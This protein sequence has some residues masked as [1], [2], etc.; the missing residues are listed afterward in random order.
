M[1]KYKFNKIMTI[2]FALVLL[3]GNFQALNAE[4]IVNDDQFGLGKVK[5]EWGRKLKEDVNL[6]YI[7][8]ENKHG[9]QKTHVIEFKPENSSI[10]AK[11]VYGEYMA[12][13]NTLSSLVNRENNN[14]SEVVFAIN[15]DGYDTSNMVPSGMMIND[16]YLLTSSPSSRKSIGF[17]QNGE[18]IRGDSNIEISVKTNNETYKVNSFNKERKN[19]QQGLYLLSDIFSTSTRSTY[20]GVEVVLSKNDEPEKGLKINDSFDVQVESVNIVENNPSMNNTKI[21]HNKMVLSAHKNSKH[22]E[23]LKDL[24]ENQ[25]LE[26]ETVNKSEVPWDKAQTAIG[27]FT[28][29]KEDGQIQSIV[30]TDKDYHPRTAIGITKD[31]RLLLMQNDGRQ[32]GHAQGVT[33]KEI[34]EH[35]SSLGAETVYNFDGGGSSTVTAKLPGYEDATVLNRPSDGHERSNANALLFIADKVEQSEL[36][37]LHIYP[38]Q[39]F[40]S[41]VTLLEKGEIGFE[42]FGTDKNYNKVAINKEDIEWEIDGQIG[43][44]ENQV[45][46]ANDKKGNGTVKVRHKKHDAIG[47]LDVDVVD[48]LTSLKSKSTIISVGP[49]NKTELEF[50]GEF[51]G[52]TVLLSNRSLSFKLSD[53]K[54]GNV[55]EDG[56]FH[57]NDTSGTGTLTVSYKDY[58]IDIPVEVG[59]LPVVLNGFERELEEDNWHWRFFNSGT[60]GGD[61]K[62][63][64]NY[65]ERYIKRGDGS[66]RID[67][68]NATNPVTGT[69]TIEAG[70][71][72]GTGQLEGKPKAIGMWVY[73]DGSGAWIRIQLK[74]ASY[75]GDVKVDWTGWKYIETPIPETATFPYDLVWGIRVLTL[76]SSPNNHKKGTLYF[77]EL[78]AVYDFKNDDLN[79][80][81]LYDEKS[82]YPLEGSTNV[83]NNSEIGLHVIDS[84]EDE[85]S[86]TGINLS[87]TKLW[88]NGEIQE[89]VQQEVQ[90]DGSVK[91]SYVPSA[92]KLLRSGNNHVKFR[93]EDN[94][95]NKFFKEWSFNV[96][97]YA[98]EL[99]ESIPEVDFL[100]P[101]QIVEYKINSKNFK[102][103][104]KM[105]ALLSYNKDAMKLIDIKADEKLDLQ[106]NETDNKIEL[107]LLGMNKYQTKNEMLSLRFKILDKEGENSNLVFDNLTVYE[108]DK[109]PAR[110]FLKGMSKEVKIPYS[111]S[112]DGVTHNYPSRFS[113][114]DINGKP[115]QNMKLQVLDEN[116]TELIIDKNSDEQGNII[117]D[118]ITKNKV[119][120]KF[121]IYAIDSQGLK[122]NQVDFV[123]KESLGT[124]KIEKVVVSTKQD[125]SKELGI[126][127]QT[128]LNV[129]QSNI[130][131]SETESFEDY[132][133]Y[134]SKSKTVPYNLKGEMRLAKAW[135]SDLTSLKPDTEYFYRIGESLENSD[136]FTLKTANS[137]KDTI[138]KFYGDFQGAFNNY[139]KIEKISDEI[140]DADLIMHAGDYSDNHN[141]YDE[142]GLIDSVLHK[143]TSSKIWAHTIGNHDV[144]ENG[145]DNVINAY[146]N[147]PTNGTDKNG[148]NYYF[149]HG[150]ARIYVMDSEAHFTYDPG[151]KNQIKH[152]EKVFKESDQTYKIVMVH[153]PPYGMSYNEPWMQIL[154]KEFDRLGI[155]LVLS[156]HD[157]IY[158]RTT[159]LDNQKVELNQGPT[160]VIMG[161]S[162][163]SK[164]YGADRTRPWTNVVY[165]KH[166]P[167]FGYIIMDENGLRFETYAYVNDEAVKIDEFL[168]V[169]N[170]KEE[171]LNQVKELK[172]V[173]DYKVTSSSLKEIEQAILE[174]EE[175]ILN[176]KYQESIKLV[177]EVKEQ[178]VFLSEE[179]WNLN[180]T[181][182]NVKETLDQ[183]SI[184]KIETVLNT[185][186][187]KEISSAFELIFKETNTEVSLEQMKKILNKSFFSLGVDYYSEK[188]LLKAENLI[189]ENKF[190]ELVQHIF[191]MKEEYDES[192]LDQIKES[193]LT[194]YE[195]DQ[196]VMTMLKENELDLESL[197]I[198]LSQEIK[199]YEDAILLYQTYLEDRYQEDRIIKT[200]LNELEQL[201]FEEVNQETLDV[202]E[203]SI[204]NVNEEYN[205][206]TMDEFFKSWSNLKLLNKSA[207]E[208][209][210][211]FIDKYIQDGNLKNKTEES[212]KNLVLV[213]DESKEALKAPRS[214]QKDIDMQVEKLRNAYTSLKEIR[215]IEVSKANIVQGEKF[216]LIMKGFD[217]NSE[218]EIM[219]HS[220]PILLGKVT[221]DS[222]GYAKVNLTIPKDTKEG[223]HKIIIDGETIE[224]EVNSS[225]ISVEPQPPVPKEPDNSN[226]KDVETDSVV[227]N[228][229]EVITDNGNKQDKHDNTNETINIEDLPKTGEFF[230]NNGVTF[231]N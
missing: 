171:A 206:E 7:S 2:L 113:I 78:R 41:S 207:L 30:N 81:H 13:G 49:G 172:N 4:E 195:K 73:G 170:Y 44:I 210:I 216:D 159:M 31:N 187:N 208:S 110:L 103:F 21:G 148:R 96:E 61:G 58:A 213:L 32:A 79:A 8:S 151:F 69:V 162:T 26:I 27:I 179:F 14:K 153:R 217:K 219:L 71:K 116:G 82:I 111:L 3:L 226:G 112:Y 161:T 84:K 57:A 225:S 43:T 228:D 231:L 173:I 16:G 119:G 28:V 17:L 65:D 230:G 52:N 157:H 64:I 128:S 126:S 142:W 76:P 5:M 165:D 72:V 192:Y 109:K 176:E 141:D 131:V 1:K 193:T 186:D 160:Y 101:G 132:K 203:Q 215:S 22:Y 33:F 211:S 121:K 227:E 12:G 177:R 67:Y 97:G 29:L 19:D 204:K 194:S 106:Y 92:L 134:P 42:V 221:T 167:S 20:E 196:L 63:S 149:D 180:F 224:I 91:I 115:A 181:F 188:D 51:E 9:L 25:S 85:K 212:K 66:L 40:A 37:A 154:H 130:Y 34:V 168:L 74:P 95:G 36:S 143:S 104:E 229:K 183:D 150:D 163:G 11:A 155:D 50:T 120:S 200:I 114:R 184:K 178:I 93:V 23:F 190:D 185:Q 123:V 102:D 68:D 189:D 136:I 62:V 139:P 98:V 209:E 24:K 174:A 86:Y 223:K 222:I 124:E 197:S 122:S 54:L 129:E 56:V 6:K 164:Y 138:I 45:L 87:R 125:P 77:D 133:T 202:F 55:D 47:T 147:K 10:K 156:G 48:E 99:E 80:P 218:Y 108:T 89:N 105:T 90:K 182:L 191:L 35:L 198:Y 145:D 205:L 75:V 220:K 214:Y 39:S 135:S 127:W 100:A 83:K 46:R 70:P 144:A 152:M 199:S 18:I 201:K 158:S 38:E 166:N 175:L 137:E 140:Y 60:R 107:S 146:F 118:L 117:T 94:A 169:K 53:E 59:K 88:I 15:G